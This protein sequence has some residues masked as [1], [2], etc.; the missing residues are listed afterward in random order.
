MLHIEKIA[1]FIPDTSNRIMDSVLDLGI[2]PQQAKILVKLYGLDRI[3]VARYDDICGLIKKSIV[4]LLDTVPLEEIKYLIHTHT[5]RVVSP[6]GESAIHQVKSELNLLHTLSFGISLNNCASV[7]NALN[8]INILLRDGSTKTKAIVVTG[9]KTFS[10]I[11]KTIPKTSIMGEASAA[12]L[13]SLT[14]NYHKLISNFSQTYG[15]YS[16]GVWQSAK[17]DIEFETNYSLMLAASIKESLVLA[18]LNLADIKIIFP[19]NVN[20]LSWRK[21]AKVLAFPLEK[22]YLSNVRRTAHCFGA[23]ILINCS[24]AIDENLIQ[25]GDYYLLATVGLGATF[26]AAV[27][28]Y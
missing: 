26:A 28:Q 16:G 27:F 5:S 15:K 21:A 25:P 18:G 8:I 19:H 20:I 9:D 3:P 14:G 24:S 11:L 4:K 1:S 7:L 6:F 22:I 10:S 13:L 12:V 2:S 17:L 23:D